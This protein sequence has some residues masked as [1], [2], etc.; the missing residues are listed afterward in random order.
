MARKYFLTKFIVSSVTGLGLFF[1]SAPLVFASASVTTMA[2]ASISADTAGG[3]YTALTGPVIQEGANRDFPLSNTFTLNA[4]SGFAFNTGSNV[5]A[6][7]TRIAGSGTCFNFSSL[8]RTPTATT[9]T[10]THSAR[11]QSGTTRCQVSFSGMQVRPTAGTPLVT[12]N[13]T[14]GGTGTVTGLATGANLGTLTETVGAKNKL[15]FTT[16][17][18]TPNTIATDFGTKP[19]VK[20]Q[21]QFG[22]PITADTSAVALS[23]VL[24]GQACGGTPGTGSITSTPASGANLVAGVMTYTAMQYSAS[25]DIHVCAASAGVTS[26]KSNAVTINKKTTTTGLATSLTPQVYGTSVTFTATVTPASGGPATGTVTFKDGVTTIGTGTLSSGVATYST[27]TLSVAGS[28]H[29]ITA[30]YGGDSTFSGSTSSAVNQ[31]MTTKTLTV[32][33]VT[34]NDKIY[35]RGL[36]ATLNTGSASLVGVVSGDT[37]TLNTA[38]A[39]GAFAT[40]TVGTGKTVTVSGLALSGASAGNY[41]LT[42]PTGITASI[43][44]LAL[45]VTGMT[46]TNKEY[47]GG[48]TATLSGGTLVG[49]I[50][51]DTVSINTRTGTFADKTVGT[52][53]PITVTSV[54]LSGADSAN[55][56]VTNP[57]GITANITAK[58]LTVTGMTATTR[59]YDGGVTAALTGG[60]LVGVINPDVVSINT[61]IG[62]FATKTVGTGKVITVTSVTLSGTDSGNYTVTNPTGVTGNITAKTLTVTGMMATNKEYDGGITATLFGGTLVGV[63]NPD[64]VSIDTRTGSFATKTVGTGK[65]ITVTSV[66]LTGTDAANYTVTNPTDVTANITAKELTVTGMSATGREYDAGTTV[67][68]SGGTLVGVINPDVVSINTR[69]GSF[70]D[71]TV[72][73]AKPITVT[74]VTLSGADSS[75]YTAA[76]ST[77]VTADITVKTITVTGVTADNKAYDGNDTAVVNTT[78]ASLVGVILGD[79]VT[80]NSA[81]AIG[82]FDTAS[83]GL[84]KPVTISGLALSGTDSANYTLTQPTGIT[85]NIT[86]PVPVTTNISP[87]SKETG[88]AGFTLTVNGSGFLSSSIVKFNGSSRTTTFVNGGQL[89]AEILTSDLT[90]ATTSALITVTNPAPGGGTSN[91]QTFVVVHAA[92]QFVILPTTNGTV[93]GTV[94]VTVQAQKA[95]GAIDATY[96]EDVTLNTTGSATGA[97]LVNIIDGEGTL[98]LSDHTA[99]TV[100]LSL[101]DSQ[102]TLLAVTSTQNIVFAAGAVT[103]FLLN[104]PGSTMNARTRLGYQI[105]RKDQY[106]NSSLAGALNAYL[107]STSATVHHAF[108]S[109][110][111]GGD[112]VTSVAFSEGSGTAS[113]WY[114]DDIPGTYTLTASDHTPTADGLSGIDDASRDIT[115]VP[116]AVKFVVITASSTSVDSPLTV[117][118]Q[119]Q[120]ADNDIDTSFQEDV[121]LNTTGSATGAGLVDIVNGVG[122]KQIS[123]TLVGNTTLSLSDTEGTGLDVTSSAVVSWTGGA[124]T[125]VTLSDPT[126]L[127][128]GT[129]KAYTLTRKDQHGNITTL[130]NTTIYLY[131]SSVS[132]NKKFY[133]AAT[134]G[135]IITSITIPDGQSTA[136]FWYYDE[137]LGTWSITASDGTP[138]AN[139]SSGISDAVDVLT[140]VTGPVSSFAFNTPGGMTAETRLG[141]TVT[142][143]DQ[144]GN[145]VTSGDTAVYLSTSAG[146]LGTIRFFYDEATNGNSISSFIIPDGSSSASFWYYEETPGN[147]TITA[148]DVDG[149]PDGSTG[150]IDGTRLVT[151]SPAPIVATRF[152]ILP[153]ST[154]NVDSPLTITIQSQDDDANLD[155]TATS[156]VMLITSGSATGAGLVTMT[157]GVGTIQISDHAAETVHLSLS[158]TQ[159]TGLSVS[160][161]QD[162]VFTTGSVAQFSMDNPGNTAAGSRLGLI[163]TRKDQYGNLI[164]SG[165][166]T[167]HLYSSS[168]GVN[169]K[170]YDASSGGTVIT[171]V[172]FLDGQSTA[173]FWYYDELSGSATVTASDNAT[174]PDGAVGT[175]DTFKTFTVTPAAIA[176]FVLDNPG[177]MTARTR[178]PYTITRKDTFNNVVTSG[179]VSAY[180][181][182]NST[183]TSTKFYD[184][185]TGGTPVTLVSFVDGSATSHFWYYEETPGT[186]VVTVSDGTPV[187]NGTTGLQDTA[188][189][190][191]VTVA[192]ITATRFVVQPVSNSSVNVPVTVTIRAEDD[193]G[194]V[195]TAYN[196]NVTLITSG[197]A[198]GGGS[199]TMIGGVGTATI[200]DTAAE[201][202]TLSLSDTLNTGL[203]VSSIQT[204]SF[205]IGFVPPSMVSIS[206]ETGPEYLTP[207]ISGIRFSGKAF[208]GASLNIVAIGGTNSLANQKSIA[209]TNGNFSIS[210]GDLT[211]GA[212]SYGIVGTDKNNNTTQVKIFDANKANSLLQ[213]DVNGILLSPTIGLSRTAVT[214]GD[215]LG[216]TGAG[217]PSY[218]IEVQVDNQPIAVTTAV[219]SKGTYKILIPTATL[220]FGSHTIRTR[221]ISSSGLKSDYSPQE[222]FSVVNIFTPNMDFNSDG[223]IGVSDYSIFVSRWQSKDAKLKAKDDLNGDKKVDIQDLSIFVKTLKK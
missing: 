171:S 217:A 158:D 157:A 141:Y 128:A 214:K 109:D 149:I 115:V 66:T 12:A 29:S 64:V 76:N 118:V 35:D 184:V 52:A 18:S 81:S 196:Q 69:T 168:V 116:V 179:I 148:S 129:R 33:G 46:A 187:A 185:V 77:D 147:Y 172:N 78:G 138:T 145:L 221:Q 153:P 223:V 23:A 156:S 68:L 203:N 2:S 166:T 177:N 107:Y 144:F 53:K 16:Q 140:V 48:V 87:T 98:T 96:Q 159:N 130:G 162:A 200:N 194:N 58:A 122:T 1:V 119:A 199:I 102:N 190:V 38:G 134:E 40:K 123:N 108:Y 165:I 163:I 70:A 173:Q 94:V 97:G 176:K 86:N 216:I 139:G 152:V 26:A 3:S 206:G 21:D 91:A 182:S 137:A 169:K 83:V 89:T 136:Q 202:V 117:T 186:W 51:G 131:S 197:S 31:T 9:I 121:T 82:T 30:V 22:N 50:S 198:T 181:Y 24:S 34:A 103:Q 146:V 193:N 143:K 180:L 7:I 75:N 210:F 28:P 15:G 54:T 14:K 80:L 110:S 25:E 132:S 49:V 142:R 175:D 154:G 104:N 65:A 79:I 164:T 101:T 57:T 4:P 219:D 220:D 62:T 6:T 105:T 44:A 72:G 93:D 178:L 11:D 13:I 37:V 167:A 74:S 73:T 222:V 135:N 150:I 39:T 111:L 155:T 213:L 5:T 133:D 112:P 124:T 211:S 8:T 212:R 127:P 85:A 32:T 20:M 106:G 188:D 84:N 36:T 10:F 60:T 191:T 92:T 218:K 205:V 99:E 63:I 61:R 204:L 192:T 43:T 17:P 207:V 120:K 55:Y 113:F 174:E 47:D 95:N 45:T 90:V 59:E 27:S 114:Y 125:Q 56:T 41:T 208:P 161:T 201:T 189:S 183:A 195:D 151:V 100:H 170:F 88:E 71:K 19:V 209:S 42:Q 215:V 126:D 67:T 160:S